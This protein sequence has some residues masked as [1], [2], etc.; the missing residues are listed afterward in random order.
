MYMKHQF[1]EI[2]ISNK[3]SNLLICFYNFDLSCPILEKYTFIENLY[4]VLSRVIKWCSF[5]T[6]I[7]SIYFRMLAV[8]IDFG[9]FYVYVWFVCMHACAHAS[10]CVCM[11]VCECC[12]C[13]EWCIC[14]LISVNLQHN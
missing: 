8:L 6:L 14:C 3:I 5:L 12:E 7:V 1:S 9:P 11:Y 13:C 2:A 4:T 10:L